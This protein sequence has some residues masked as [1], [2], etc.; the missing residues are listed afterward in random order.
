M[1]KASLSHCDRNKGFDCEDTAKPSGSHSVAKA[2]KRMLGLS[3]VVGDIVLAAPAS[4]VHD[5]S[6]LC[7]GN[8]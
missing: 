7:L 1:P 3:E 5:L 8:Q 6:G 2:M 4:R